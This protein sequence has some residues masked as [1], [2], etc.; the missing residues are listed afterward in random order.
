VPVDEVNVWP[1]TP[2][3]VMV[4][5]D[6]FAGAI[7]VGGGGG[8]GDAGAGAITAVGAD[9]A[10]AV[11]FLFVASTMIRRVFPTSATAKR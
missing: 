7:V 11:P 9:G 5:G 8:G 10:L 3:P 2:V 6:V 1:L 4:G